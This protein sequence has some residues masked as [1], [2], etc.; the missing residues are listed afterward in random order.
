MTYFRR[1]EMKKASVF[2]LL[3]ISLLLLSVWTAQPQSLQL[4]EGTLTSYDGTP[5][6]NR[7]LVIEGT[8]ESWWAERL[9]W[10]G[11]KKVK[12]I[13]LTD[14]KGF[15]QVVDLPAGDYTLTLTQPGSNS[16]PIKSFKLEPGYG[17][18]ELT[19]KIEWKDSYFVPDLPKSE[20]P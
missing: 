8:K 17:K 14:T 19:G 18:R 3:M 11:W 2:V 15:F 4:V 20:K 16:I 9:P 5:L 7:M 13:S 10:L 12:I 1:S 6:A